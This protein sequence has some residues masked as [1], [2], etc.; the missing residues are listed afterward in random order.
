[1]C[2]CRKGLE[3]MKKLS[4]LY[5]NA[6]FCLFFFSNFLEGR[7]ASLFEKAVFLFVLKGGWA[8][9]PADADIQVFVET[10]TGKTMT[11]EVDPSD[12]TENVKAK[13]QD[14]DSIPSDQK[15]LI[16]VGKQLEDGR[17]LSDYN[18]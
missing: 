15:S 7:N 12:T 16:F 13:I 8:A 6:V 2:L 9:S 17:I 11:L 18:I 1:M 5:F 10:L 14:R 3:I 4:C